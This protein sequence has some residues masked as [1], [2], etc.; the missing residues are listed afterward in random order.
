[1]KVLQI[2]GV[3]HQG[4][5]GNIV[6]A[7][8]EYVRSCG[9]DCFIAYGIGSNTTDGYKF[10][11]RYEQA[12]YRRCS[13][14]T[15][16]RYGFAP[17]ATKRLL[18]FIQ[19]YKPDVVHLHSINGNC[20]N[21]FDLLAYLKSNNI[22]TVVT[23]HAEFFY[24]G[25]CT[26]T[27]GCTKYIDGCQ[28][29]SNIKWASD[30]ALFPKTGY[31]WE[32]MRQAFAGFKNINITCVSEYSLR[33]SKKSPILGKY[34]HSVIFNGVDTDTFKP[35]KDINIRK[36]YNLSAKKIALFVTPVFSMEK[37]HL[38]GGYWLAEL[39]KKYSKEEMQFLV[40]GNNG[41]N[42]NQSN[43]IFAGVVRD[44]HLLANIYSQVDI[45]LG[46]SKSESFGM[47][48]AEALCCG[49][50]FI[51]FECGGMESIA[52]K[53]FSRFTKYGDLDLME[54]YIKEMLSEMKGRGEYIS[55]I[56][57]NYYS[58]YRMVR[59]YYELYKKMVDNN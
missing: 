55:N 3:I 43:I 28:E 34:N 52:I 33:C 59:N 40:V 49:T 45:V 23:N 5:T 16:F 51:G 6:D 18:R 4:S 35:V 31:A 20:V 2:N 10:C 26:S 50:P 54:R 38:K 12:L 46:F 53:E 37:D 36:K 24:T 27:Y 41:T 7:I 30:N 22:P 56:A 25:N 15:G 14:L 21:I 39:S 9:N 48:C 29:C 17:L 42:I 58:D 32:K 57:Q 19:K 13:M 8:A 11:Y 44:R 1:M 47:T